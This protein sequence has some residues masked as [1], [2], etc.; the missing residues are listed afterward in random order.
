M[1]VGEPEHDRYRVN[2][3]P[4]GFDLIF[5]QDGTEIYRSS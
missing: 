4:S 3:S 2:V 5:S 1:I